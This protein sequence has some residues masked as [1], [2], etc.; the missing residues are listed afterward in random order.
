[1]ATVTLPY[2]FVA[3]AT[4]L[5]SEVNG[6]FNAIVTE[7]NGN[8]SAANL[9]NGAVTESKLDDLSVATGKIQAGAVTDAKVATGISTTKIGGGLVDDTEFG[10]LNGVTSSIQAQ[11]DGKLSSLAA[12]SVD[13]TELADDAVTNAKVAV[14]AVDTAQIVADAVTQAKIAAGSVD[15]TEL[16]D[17]A[18][19][20]AK[21]AAQAVGG[22]P[23]LGPAT[24][25]T[26][27]SAPR[28]G[29]DLGPIGTNGEV[30]IPKGAWY[31]YAEPEATWGIYVKMDGTNDVQ[32]GPGFSGG[33]PG[34]VV[35]DGTNVIIAVLSN[36][37]YGVFL[38]EAY[39]A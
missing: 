4:A 23:S 32:M 36:G 1:M 30:A 26:S 24:G 10:Y 37:G 7:V 5:A 34:I 28:P 16:A 31:V 25:S 14:D 17:G 12:G 27:A 20:A 2:T 18:V 6:N 29:I 13:T 11:L 19:T 3:G 39:L 15:T 22:D 8:L 21:I 33:Y 9:A 35:S 38:R